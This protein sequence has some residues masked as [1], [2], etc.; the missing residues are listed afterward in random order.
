MKKLLLIGMLCFSVSSLLV[1]QSNAFR[2]IF[3]KYENEENVTVI[4]ISKNMLNLIPGNIQTGTSIDIKNIVP[5]I[6][7]ILILSADSS[8]VVEKMNDDFKLLLNN[9]KYEELMRIKDNKS[10]IV[11][12]VTKS[13]DFISELVMLVMEKTNFVAIQILG[14][15]TLDEIKSI[16][17]DAAKQ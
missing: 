7:S 16:T 12:S 14:N 4:S 5:K 15:F 6:E 10:N 11:F 8:T 1:A 2:H 17:A 3:E 13:G 9:K